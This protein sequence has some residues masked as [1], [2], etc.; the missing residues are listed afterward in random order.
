MKG[1][2]NEK[3]DCV[4]CYRER[5]AARRRQAEVTRDKFDDSGLRSVQWPPRESQR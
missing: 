3:Y 4:G 1:R 2:R 5:M